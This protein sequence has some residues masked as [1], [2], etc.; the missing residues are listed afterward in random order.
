[1]SITEQFPDKLAIVTGLPIAKLED[2]L[3]VS[4]VTN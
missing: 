3:T 2:K 4:I 1:M